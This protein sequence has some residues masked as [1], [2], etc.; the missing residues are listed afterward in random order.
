MDTIGAFA[1]SIENPAIRT[2]GMLLDSDIA[3]GALILSLLLLGERRDQKRK[4]ILLAIAL[5]VVLG[6][7][8]KYALAHERPCI[9]EAWCP[10]D[11]AFPSLHATIAFTL[12]MGFIN[13]RSYWL[14]LIFALFVSFTRLNLGVHSFLDIAG[15]LPLGMMA[16]YATHLS[17]GGDDDG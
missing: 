1:L 9:G 5:A 7:G 8:I 16:Y 12:M 15:A 4:K 10:E 2:I 13:K 14:Y 11:Y 6:Y 3:Y 17:F